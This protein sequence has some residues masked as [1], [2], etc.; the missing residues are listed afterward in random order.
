MS[1]NIVIVVESRE[2]ASLDRIIPAS[3][4][5]GRGE[6]RGIQQGTVHG[7]QTFLAFFNMI[8]KSIADM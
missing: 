5:S 8:A 6:Q 2:A 1:Y 7:T 3:F 4:S